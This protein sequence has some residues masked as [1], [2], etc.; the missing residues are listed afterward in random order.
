[1]ADVPPQVSPRVTSEREIC[2]GKR[3]VLRR[4][5]VS[6][7][8]AT[9]EADRVAFGPSVVILPVLEDGRV[10]L[11]RQWRAAVNGWVLEAPAGRMEPGEAPEEAA[12]RELEEETGY[13][14]A[15][16]ERMYSA[17]VSPGY[18]DEVQHAFIATGL[19]RARQALEPDEVI[20]LAP[21]TVG[22]YLSAASSGTV[23]LK[24]LALVLLYSSR[25]ACPCQ[26]TG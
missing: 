1:M 19:S 16:L 18:S 2:R 9:F 20:R 23:D 14:A 10:L 13:R 24:T 5:S 25:A 22:E 11:I 15:R 4:L 12:R 26:A 17:Y 3:V 21:M 8:S 6:Y 7:G